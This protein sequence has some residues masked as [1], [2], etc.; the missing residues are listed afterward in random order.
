[1]D[2]VIYQGHEGSESEGNSARSSVTG[3]TARRGKDKD[4]KII[5]EK[6][7]DLS[8]FREAPIRPANSKRWLFNAN[9]LFTVAKVEE[10]GPLNESSPEIAD[11]VKLNNDEEDSATEKTVSQMD[12]PHVS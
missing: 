5:R 7:P 12:S 3:A 9:K 4:K 2:D 1:M 8:V 6:R 10:V 11:I